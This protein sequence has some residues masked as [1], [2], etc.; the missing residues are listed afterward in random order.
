MHTPP[1]PLD[2]TPFG[3]T[4]TESLVYEVLVTQGPGT[5][6]AIAR[7]AGLARA[8]AYSALGGLVTKGA[9]RVE[10]GR[11]KRYRPEPPPVLLS[12][13]VDRQGQAVEQLSQA[14][15]SISAPASPTVTE[16]TSLRGL[17]QMITLEAARAA[18]SVRLHLPAS[19]YAGLGPALRRVAG[20]AVGLELSADEPVDGLPVPIA[21]HPAGNRWPGQ[22]LLGVIDGR[23]ALIGTLSAGEP[24]GFWTTRPAL[25]AAAG[26]ALDGLSG[27]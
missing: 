24:D 1:V 23:L 25:V 14:L 8:N 10:N 13:I 15:S 5:G 18:E 2:L 11:P 3:F 16:V 26:H 21:V 27:R 4:P 7:S 22:P 12:R 17:T 9:A 6:Y 20:L 19:V